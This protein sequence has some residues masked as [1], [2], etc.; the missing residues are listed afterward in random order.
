ML[1]RH[2]VKLSPMLADIFDMVEHSGQRGITREVLGYVFYPDKNRTA[3][4]R[5]ITA[6]I[7][8]INSF[9]E[10]T[11]YCIRMSSRPFG[12]YRVERR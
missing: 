2:G 9:L 12:V 10:S 3:G 7:W 6:N 5:C 11:D 8:H 1:R 4:Q